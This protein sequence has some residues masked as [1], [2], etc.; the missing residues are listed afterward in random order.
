MQ[1]FHIRK[2]DSR[3]SLCAAVL[4]LLLAIS[5]CS[6]EGQVWLSTPEGELSIGSLKNSRLTLD[7]EA[8]Y[9]YADKIDKSFHNSADLAIE[10]DG[11]RTR[12][13]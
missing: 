5:S 2:N 7:S 6:S 1:S 13:G 9:S 8:S 11:F 10:T 12:V 3:S 4:T